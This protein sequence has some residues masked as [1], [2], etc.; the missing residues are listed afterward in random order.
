MN[1]E[2]E[3]RE[4]LSG[5]NDIVSFRQKYDTDDGIHINILD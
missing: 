1:A 3:I 5:N 4:F 2:A